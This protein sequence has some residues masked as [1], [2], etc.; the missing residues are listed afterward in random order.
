MKVLQINTTG[1]SAS[2]GRIAAGIGKQLILGGHESYLAYGRPGNEC[3][4]ELIKIGGKLDQGLHMVKSRLFDRHGFSSADATRSLIRKIDQVE[5]DIIHL[6]NLHGYYLNI[7]VLFTFLKEWGKPVAWT[8]HD[9]WPITGHCSYFE[10]MN[11][12]KWETLCYD[13][14]NIKG[15]PKSWFIDNSRKNYLQKKALFTGLKNLVLVSP[16]QWLAKYLKRSFLS[17]F[18]VRI[19]YNGVDT[20]KFNPELE[21]LTKGKFSL[22]KKYILGVANIWDER[23]GLRDFISLRRILDDEIEIVLVG[24][25]GQQKK[26]LGN[27]IR[28]ILRT[29]S[30]S[31]LA[32]LYAGAEAFVNPTYLDNFPLVNIEALSCGTPVITYRTGGSHESVDDSTGAIVEKGNV[33]ALHDTIMQVINDK[34]LFSAGKCRERAIEKFSAEDRYK[35]YLRLYEERIALS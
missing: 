17:D 18:E 28:G 1:N 5:P 14:P 25:S 23:K 20:V 11:C 27:G 31:D 4:S 33:S 35:D 16:S 30:V 22:T 24:I 3:E 2:H 32:S 34:N 26:A 8:F 10:H 6:H 13:C 29:E 21:G 7:E 9:T 15:Y 19:I 12:F